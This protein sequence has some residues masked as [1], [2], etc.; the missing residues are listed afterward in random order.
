MISRVQ[1][2]VHPSIHDAIGLV[3]LTLMMQIVFFWTD[4]EPCF[5]EISDD[6]VRF[7][8]HHVSPLV[9]F[10]CENTQ[11]NSKND[12]PV[13]CLGEEGCASSVDAESNEW[14]SWV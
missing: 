7:N 11:R 5:L 14:R 3:K 1:N 13:H 10:I 9:A 12:H 8:V 6:F 4:N 2:W